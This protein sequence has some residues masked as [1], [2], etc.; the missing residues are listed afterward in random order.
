MLALPGTAA[1]TAVP[2]SQLALTESQ[3]NQD[4]KSTSILCRSER[5]ED[6][7]NSCQPDS[8]TCDHK[9]LQQ[10]DLHHPPLQNKCEAGT[11]SKQM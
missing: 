7:K 9:T 5:N 2:P 8:V 6:N 4:V 10:K 1:I 11:S 3:Q